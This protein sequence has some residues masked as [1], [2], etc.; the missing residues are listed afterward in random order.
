VERLLALLA[1]L[2]A[3]MELIRFPAYPTVDSAF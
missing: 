1:L 3:G 2:A